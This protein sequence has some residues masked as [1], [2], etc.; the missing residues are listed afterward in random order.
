MQRATVNWG[1]SSSSSEKGSRRKLRSLQDTALLKARTLGQLD[2]FALD[3]AQSERPGAA[4]NPMSPS[5]FVSRLHV[6]QALRGAGHRLGDVVGPSCLSPLS[7]EILCGLHVWSAISAEG[8]CDAGHRGSG[9]SRQLSLWAPT[10]DAVASGP[11]RAAD[12][13]V[14]NCRCGPPRVIGIWRRLEQLRACAVEW[15]R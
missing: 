5:H 11:I 12:P 13:D 7:E 14:S 8:V 9:A 10:R 6:A 2:H 4:S 15:S 1:G 3:S